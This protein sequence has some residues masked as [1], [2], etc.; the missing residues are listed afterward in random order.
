MDMRLAGLIAGHMSI[1][2]QAWRFRESFR[3]TPGMFSCVIL[4]VQTHMC[5]DIVDIAELLH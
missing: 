1:A 4:D 2:C 5:S 3:D